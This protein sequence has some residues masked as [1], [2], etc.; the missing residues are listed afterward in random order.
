MKQTG[1]FARAVLHKAL[2]QDA[3]A[4]RRA[5][6]ETDHRRQLTGDLVDRGAVRAILADRLGNAMP[7][8]EA[9]STYCTLLDTLRSA[10]FRAQRQRGDDA[11]NTAILAAMQAIQK[12]LAD[13]GPI[14]AARWKDGR[15][16]ARPALFAPDTMADPEKRARI[17]ELEIKHAILNSMVEA[18]RLRSWRDAPIVEPWADATETLLRA[19]GRP[20]AHLRDKI[21]SDLMPL[22][23][24]ETLS[25]GP[26]IVRKAIEAVRRAAETWHLTP[27]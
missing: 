3:P 22:V 6:H 24:G 4:R 16:L 25:D 7:P 2:H 10:L 12:E 23:S 20:R 11:V 8:D 18:P 27:G 26:E 5:N 9:F 15:M 1:D 13:L 21:M 14:V 17:R 19:A